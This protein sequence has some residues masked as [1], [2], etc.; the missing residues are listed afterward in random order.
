LNPE[1]QATNERE[2][3]TAARRPKFSVLSNAKMESLGIEPMPPLETAIELYLKARE[4]HFNPNT[5][6]AT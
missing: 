2:Y 5:N 1:L 6:N 3:R 4:A